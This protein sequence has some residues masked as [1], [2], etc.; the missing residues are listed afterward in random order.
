M[1]CVH[2]H[3]H[4]HTISLFHYHKSIF[5]VKCKVRPPTEEGAVAV[6]FCMCIQEVFG[7]N[8][9]QYTYLGFLWLF[10]VPPGNCQ[11]STLIGL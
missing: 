3:T 7:L 6:I 1:V 8:L 10:S 2:T 9:D 5:Y 11:E 4:T